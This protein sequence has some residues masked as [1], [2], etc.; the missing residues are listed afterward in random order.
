[1]TKAIDLRPPILER[2][3]EFYE[4]DEIGEWMKSPHP[5][6]GGISPSEAL[7]RGGFDEV[8]EIIDRLD[9]GVHL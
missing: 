8:H 7:A 9:T 5:Q 6:L 2:L 4:P 3:M 1:M